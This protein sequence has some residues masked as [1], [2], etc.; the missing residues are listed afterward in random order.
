MFTGAPNLVELLS[1][2]LSHGCLLKTRIIGTKGELILE[3]TW[4]PTN[5]SSIIIT[6]ENEEKIKV[7]CHDNIYAY[8]INIL[9]NCISENK[10]EPDFPGMTVTETLENMKILDKWLN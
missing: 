7:K 5:S 8:E 3:N 2:S 6:G 10:K 9:S 1:D 4:T